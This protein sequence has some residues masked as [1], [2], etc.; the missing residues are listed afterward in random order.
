MK[1]VT[2]AQ[3]QK[4][5]Q[6]TIAEF[7]LPGRVL[8]ENAGR[9]AVRAF[10]EYFPNALNGKSVG[11]MAGPGN[12]GGDGFVM[13][14]YLSQM[15]IKLTVFLLADKERLQGDAKANFG[16][17]DKLD[18][19]VV[20]I[21]DPAAFERQIILLHH[22]EI[23]I[24]AIFGTGLN[25][26]VK[27]YFKQVIQFLNQQRQPVFSVDIPSGLNSDNG[28]PCGICIKAQATATFGF[29]KTG[30]ILLPG[31]KYSGQLNI[32]DI[33]IP[34][35]VIRAVNSPQHLL[36]G[37][38]IRDLIKKRSPDAHKGNTGH[39]LVV[40]GSTG[41]TGAAAMTAMSALRVGAGLVSLGV[42][43]A[44]NPVLESMVTE[45]MT[46][47]LGQTSCGQLD[48]QAFDE[49]KILLDAKKCLA[50]GPGIGQS[51]DLARL[52]CELLAFS[53]VPV[54]VDA[55]GLNNLA[56]NPKILKDLTIPVV[57]TPHP[58]E[59]ARLCGKTVAAIQKDRIAAARNFATEFQV[60]LVLKGASTV[61]GLPDGHIFIN[62]TGN[63]GMASG[64]M[65]DVLTGMIAGLITQ[66][67]AV[68]QASLMG[69]YL[70][71]KAADYLYKSKG[72]CGFLATEVMN[73]IPETIRD[74]ESRQTP[75]SN[76]PLKNESEPFQEV[77]LRSFESVENISSPNTP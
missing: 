41:K 43:K 32:I 20:E 62:A 47:P 15:G 57:L 24:D 2:A 66:G 42:A 8:M 75:T 30:H 63:S 48:Y 67:Y 73:F 12:N 4:M 25:S 35:L 37:A 19:K 28:Q 6:K 58:G 18:I 10:L 33:G 21:P 51:K 46:C 77:V 14:R 1:L 64:G 76:L 72:P 40:A 5:D 7:G 45:A 17:L 36:T 27:G 31:A 3:M 56:E 69:V 61:I 53:S 65:G 11:V 22:Q 60:V 68:D 44:L 29:A 26:D 54:V 39:L 16:L 49:I 70:H 23:W 52:I 71:G 9:G 59:M 74:L 38:N 50:I 13:A 55:D 34:S